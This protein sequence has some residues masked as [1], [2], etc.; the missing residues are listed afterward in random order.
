MEWRF[1]L[2]IARDG[3]APDDKLEVVNLF[4]NHNE[5]SVAQIRASCALYINGE[6]RAAQD[7]RAM[8]E[9][10]TNSLSNKGKDRSRVWREEYTID[11][12]PSG[13]LILKIIIRESHIDT[14]ATVRHLQDKLTDLKTH[15]VTLKYNIT[16]FNR[17]VCDLMDQL[18]SRGER[19]TDLFTN[20]FEAYRSTTDKRFNTY[21][22]MKFNAYDAGEKNPGNGSHAILPKQIQGPS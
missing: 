2:E 6:N 20:L 19:T 15:L 1:I 17:Y 11:G 14:K 5:L 22:E 21:I 16:E 4:T 8:Y 7:S 3:T 10:L 18:A 9:C 12:E 13:P